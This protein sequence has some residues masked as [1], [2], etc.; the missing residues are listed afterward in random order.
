[1]LANE[2]CP[3][4][5]RQTG[6]YIVGGSSNTEDEPYLLSGDLQE[7]KYCTIHSIK[8]RLP[9][10]PQIPGLKNMEEDNETTDEE[11]QEHETDDN[12]NREDNEN[13]TDEERPGE[14][15]EGNSEENH[16]AD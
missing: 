7:E 8:T 16:G 5:L 11:G 1:M 15:A 3:K 14:G 6:V 2:Y 12:G 9:K 4:K 10:T 13:G